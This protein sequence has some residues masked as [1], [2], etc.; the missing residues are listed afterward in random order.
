[1]K[2]FFLTAVL[3]ITI[4]GTA[5][6]DVVSF[7]TSAPRSVVVDQQFRISYKV[8][9]VKVGEP[10]I[11]EIDGFRILTGPHR[12]T[13]RSMQMINGET[14][15]S[16]SVTF[17]YTLLAE[18]EGEFTIPAASII[19]DGEK[20]TSN[21]AKIR[22]LPADQAGQSSQQGRSNGGGIQ[23]NT[24][25]TNISN[26][27]L[28]I[29]ASLNKTKVY[30][31]EAVLL[32]YKVYSAV[33]L[34][35]LDFPT[36][37]LKGFHIQEVELPK[38]KQFELDRYNGRNYQSLVWRQ[39]VLFPQQSGK[40]EIPSLTFEG[41]VAVQTRRSMD[42]FEMMFNGG[43][44][45]VEVK[46]SIRTNSLTLNVEKLPAGKP[47]G[48]S[49]GVGKFSISSS[50]SN[51]NLKTNEEVTLKVIVKG[52]GNMKLLGDPQI[53]FPSEFEVYD[54]IINNNFSLR[55]SGFTGEKVYEYVITP[56][57]SG[58][59]T[60][61]AAKFSYFDTSSNSYRTIESES[62][63]LDVEK[64]KDAPAATA[65]L[66][67]GKE[68]GRVLATD[69]RHIKLDEG[70]TK[71]EHT[72]L[73][74][75][76][77]YVLLYIIPLLLFIAYI[78]V[79]RRKMAENANLTLVRTKK[80]NK[81]AVKRLKIANRLLKENR[82]NEFYDEI[83]K[84]MWGYMSDKLSIPVSQLS[85]ENIAAEL[86]VK[87]VDASLIDEMQDVLNEGEFARYAPGDAGATMDK[88][89]S[90]AMDVISKMENSIK[91]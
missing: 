87:G 86:A 15:T 46:K 89:Y 70:E 80:A 72:T 56:R 34:T 60:I 40:I 62:Y 3:F 61:P 17:T 9:R 84:T 91:K 26:D 41:V 45:Y 44:S 20:V 39:F 31:Q 47:A 30:E 8:N 11:P 29:R 64:G 63:T 85:K 74:G 73:F 28:F 48:F 67:I 10:T 69:I 90:R 51:T 54:P 5:F 12:S 18:K 2:R 35:N 52:V 1:M 25:S 65:N 78:I 42:P 82:K 77:T 71:K 75:S 14:T 38:E 33:N 50:I 57:S 36:P 37:E 79:Y 55:S 4:I 43:P 21:E 6:A 7:V 13:Q 58:T 32:T 76:T 23:R 68:R 24:T 59:Y 66:Y 88:V 19:V 81:V 53:D 83:L 22:V 16:E 49:G 27:D